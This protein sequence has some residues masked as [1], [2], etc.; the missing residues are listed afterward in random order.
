MELF[1]EFRLKMGNSILSKKLEKVRR[2]MSYTDISRI[3][4]I[5]IVWDA[6]RTGEFAILSKLHQKMNERGISLTILGYFP[7]KE[8]PNQY[9]ALRYFTCMRRKEMSFFYLPLSGEADK[10][11]NTRFDILIDINFE[12]VFPLFYISSLSAASFK[13]GLFDKE[14]GN[15]AF[16]LMMELKKPVNVDEYLTNVIHYLEMIKSGKNEQVEK[17]QYEKV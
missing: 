12:K 7:E 1:R 16:D 13:V 9:T 2:K 11:I 8:L 10:F 14:S 15:S 5:G 3:K 17:N 4:S 6:S